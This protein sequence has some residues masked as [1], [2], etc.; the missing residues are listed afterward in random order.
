MLIHVRSFSDSV[1]K[2]S[3]LSDE[4]KGLTL[5]LLQEAALRDDIVVLISN[6][7]QQH[8][9]KWLHNID[10]NTVTVQERIIKIVSFWE[11]FRRYKLNGKNLKSFMCRLQQE[12]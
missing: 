4:L 5:G 3:D 12:A 2:N 8:V 6:D 10:K 9:I 7:P 11:I 1:I